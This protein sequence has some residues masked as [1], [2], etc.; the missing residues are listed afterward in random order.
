MLAELGAIESPTVNDEAIALFHAMGTGMR[1]YSGEEAVDLITH[2]ERA[3]MDLLLALDFIPIWSVKVVVRK[4]ANVPMESEFRSAGRIH[5]KDTRTQTQPH[6]YALR[7]DA[8]GLT[9]L[10]ALYITAR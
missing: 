10:G 4:W 7:I 9:G 2:S 1:V 3:Y 5:T 8:G 6:R